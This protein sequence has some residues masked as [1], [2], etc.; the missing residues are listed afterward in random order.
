MAQAQIIHIKPKAGSKVFGDESFSGIL[1]GA[2]GKEYPYKGS[3]RFVI[4]GNGMIIDTSTQQG[5]DIA[6]II[7][8]RNVKVK[9]NPSAGFN[10]R[11]D[12]VDVAKDAVDYLAADEL[13]TDYKV[14][15]KN[16]K[17]IELK[18]IGFFFKLSGDENTIKAGL[19]K[20]IDND[21]TRAKV[22]AFLLH[23]DRVLLQYI[24]N[25]LQIGDGANKKGLYKTDKDLYYFNETPMG[26]G[27]DT[28][29]AFLKKETEDAKTIYSLLKDGYEKTAKG[30]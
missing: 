14:Q 28:A 8:G 27:E 20:L 19:Y 29:V 3:R 22:G 30:K 15:V 10:Y 23:P 25:G 18:T 7:K 11:F 1:I 16:M 5:K 24:F 21:K 6:D 12:I 13:K 4:P 2:S 17:S 26:L 9:F